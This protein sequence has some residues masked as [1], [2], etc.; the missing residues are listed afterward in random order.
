[1]SRELTL[2][3]LAGREIKARGKD[4]EYCSICIIIME[5]FLSKSSGLLVVGWISHSQAYVLKARH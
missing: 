4:R 2:T 3:S 1:M 5:S